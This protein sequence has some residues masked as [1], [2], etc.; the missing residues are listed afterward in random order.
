[1]FFLYNPPRHT[2]H[3]HT[4]AQRIYISTLHTCI[5]LHPSSTAKR[6][7]SDTL[8]LKRS[9]VWRDGQWAASALTPSSCTRVL[10]RT[11]C[12]REGHPRAIDTTL[13]SVTFTHS[14]RFKYVRSGQCAATANAQ[15]E[16]T[17]L[18]EEDVGDRVPCEFSVDSVWKGVRFQ[19]EWF[20]CEC[21]K[22]NVLLFSVKGDTECGL[23]S[24]GEVQCQYS[25]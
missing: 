1:M 17:P 14:Q 9:R 18:C 2:Q 19:C 5:S 7:A 21:V 15:A 13:A 6:L 16:P 24:I 3:T 20:Q 12:M 10:E 23:S 11:S 22:N 25:V 4:H 8:Q